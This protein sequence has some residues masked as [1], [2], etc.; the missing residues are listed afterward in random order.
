[1][2]IFLNKNLIFHKK[3]IKKTQTY[4]NQLKFMLKL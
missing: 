4:I 3:N 1:M 2:K